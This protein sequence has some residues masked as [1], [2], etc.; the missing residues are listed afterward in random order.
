L[1][2]RL[3][4]STSL[5][6]SNYSSSTCTDIDLETNTQPTRIFI[7]QTRTSQAIATTQQAVTIPSTHTNRVCSS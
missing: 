6:R 7:L 2:V 5:N 1:I 3:G 4:D